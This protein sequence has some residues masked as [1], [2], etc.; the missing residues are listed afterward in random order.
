[1]DE[2]TQV[3]DRTIPW[4]RAWEGAGKSKLPLFR[5]DLDVL[6][7]RGGTLSRLPG[8]ACLVARPSGLPSEVQTLQP[9][10]PALLPSPSALA[11][12][13]T[14]VRLGSL[15]GAS[16]APRAELSLV[17]EPPHH[18]SRSFTASV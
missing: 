15:G 18:L 13:H 16:C 12:Q 8:R 7:G 4:H 17:E 9:T 5:A 11:D 3:F 1:M 2:S 6:V 10:T 14:F